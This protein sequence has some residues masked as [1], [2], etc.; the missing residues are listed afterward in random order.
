MLTAKEKELKNRRAETVE[1][2]VQQETTPT[3]GLSCRKVEAVNSDNKSLKE[4]VHRLKSEWMKL[5]KEVRHK[6]ELIKTE[7]K[8]DAKSRQQ[9]LNPSV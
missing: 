8:E 2:K 7:T 9:E 1:V 3:E 6:I 4:Q 5:E